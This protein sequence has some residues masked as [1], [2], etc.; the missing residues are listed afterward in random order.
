MKLHIGCGTKY[1]P[2]YK[3]CDIIKRDHIDHVA[4]ADNLS[5]LKDN[6]V[7]EIY[8]CHVAEHFKRDKILNVFKEW[9][10]VLISGGYYVLPFQTSLQLF[11]TTIRPVILI[12]F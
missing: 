6:S 8:A 9:H 2:G 12:W 3:H 4:N 11:R 1:L 5:F 7:E 10:R